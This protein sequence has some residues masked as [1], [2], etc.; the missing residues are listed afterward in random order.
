[1]ISLRFRNEQRHGKDMAAQETEQ[2]RQI[3]LQLTDLYQFRHSILPEHRDLYHSSL[4]E[5]LCKPTANLMA[6]LT[7]HSDHLRAS[8]LEAVASNVMHTRP[9]SSYFW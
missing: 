2:V 4:D 8:H 7:K 6:W 3:I 5:H 1:M 9:N